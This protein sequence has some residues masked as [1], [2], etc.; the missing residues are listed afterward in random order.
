MSCIQL[1]E[2]F[3]ELVPFHS[4]FI[5]IAHRFET[6]LDKEK[7]RGFYPAVDY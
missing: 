6:Y 4:Q 5:C 7:V 3:S 1:L 2:Y